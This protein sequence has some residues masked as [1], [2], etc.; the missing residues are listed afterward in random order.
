MDHSA[1][2]PTPNAVR[3][4]KERRVACQRAA[5]SPRGSGKPDCK[6]IV[7]FAFNSE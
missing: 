5:S 3:R 2:G 1:N 6:L 4:K 7:L